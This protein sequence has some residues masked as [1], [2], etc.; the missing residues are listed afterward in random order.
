MNMYL[1]KLLAAEIL[2]YIIYI[3]GYIDCEAAGG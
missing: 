3:D 2:I 1:A